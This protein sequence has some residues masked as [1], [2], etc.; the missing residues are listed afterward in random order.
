MSDSPYRQ[1][2]GNAVRAL[3]RQKQIAERESWS[4]EQ[5]RAHQRERLADLVRHARAHS[6][7]YREHLD[8]ASLDDLP[9]VTK[10]EL[11]ERYDEWV[12]DPRLRRDEVERHVAGLT[13]D[14]LFAGE[15]RVMAT[16][17][18]TGRRGVFA[19]DRGE[20][21]ELCA[22]MLR[23]MD[24]F[25][26]KPKLPRRRIGTVLAPSAAHMTWRI[27]ASMDFGLYRNLRLAATQP[28][29]ELVRELNAFQPEMLGAYPS[30]AALLA[31]EQLEG[32]LRIAPG[33]VSTSSEVCTP[34]MR[35]RVRRAWGVPVHE[36]YGATDGLWGF[37]CPE[38]NHLHF[39]EDATI[40]DVED[41]RILVTNLFMRTQPVIRYEITDMVRISDEPCACGRPYRVVEAIEGRSD[42]VLRLPADAGGTVAMH[43]MHL[44]SP[45]AR[46]ETVRQYEIVHRA[47]GLHARVVPRGDADRAAAEVR[48]AL[49]GAVAGAG[50]GGV[51]VHVSAVDAIERDPAC[52]GKHKL[53]RSEAGARVVA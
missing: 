15:Y 38:A 51:A 44:R 49:Q 46:L 19:F 41:D 6:A 11:M 7:F 42:D 3:R 43:P 8:G 14:A 16:G 50:A 27:S 32:R 30:I 53:V 40:V 36:I 9:P 25:G 52:S 31:D 28:L 24:A 18:S 37:T 47:D 10:G 20:W 13:G 1:R 39:A 48:S 22:L 5:L 2:L 34:E 33:I 45:L 35:E 29:A 21:T 23:G 26:V 17:G 12:T 4:R